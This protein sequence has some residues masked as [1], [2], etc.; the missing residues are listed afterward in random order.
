MI[1]EPAPPAG[2]APPGAAPLPGAPADAQQL[3]IVRWFFFGVFAFLIYQLLLILSLFSDAIIWSSSLALVCFPIHKFLQARLPSRDGAAA[4]L[5]TLAVLLLVLVPTLFVLGVVVRQSAELYPTV[6]GWVAP[7]GALAAG[8]LPELLRGYWH[9]LSEFAGQSSLF[10]Q[11]DLQEFM[12]GNINAAS[13]RIANF[14]AVM[15]RNILFGLVNLLLILVTLF[16]CFR[17]GERFLH[18]LFDTVPM[19]VAQAQSIALR[20]YQTVTAVIRGALLTAVIQG[21]LAMIGYQIAGVPLAVFFGVMTGIAAMIPVVGA[22]L[23]WAPIGIFIFMKS[24]AWGIFVFAWGFFLVSLA[25]N[26]LKPVLI[27]SRARMPILLIFC[28]II[29][30]ANVYGVTGLMIGPIVIASLLA[31]VSIYREHYSPESGGRVVDTE[32]T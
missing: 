26:V 7:D 17:D 4:A 25:D 10:A 29:G 32:R 12:L 16:F 6:R 22:G 2:A 27:G 14:G 20:I 5:S 9:R 1:D 18:W 31:F 21:L 11:F 8:L 15:A 23:V 3:R 30:G 13:A 24:P 19:P 28:G